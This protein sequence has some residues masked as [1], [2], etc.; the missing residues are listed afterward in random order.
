[1]RAVKTFESKAKETNGLE[2]KK[3]R[4]PEPKKTL[5][6]RVK[7]AIKTQ[8]EEEALKNF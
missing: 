6:D 1:M 2:R 3:F 8:E 7:E 4:K 5:V